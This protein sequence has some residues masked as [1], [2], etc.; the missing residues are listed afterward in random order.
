[1]CGICGEISVDGARVPERNVRSMLDGMRHRGPDSEGVFSAPGISAG[2][3]RLA[4]ID[5]DGGDQPIDDETRNV[6]VVFNGEIYNHQA[7]RAWLIEKGHRFRTRTDTEVLVHLWEERGPGLVHELE[8]MFAFCIH[9]RARSATFVARDRVGIKPLFLARAGQTIVFASELGVMLRHPRI[10]AR[11]DGDA[12]VD[13]FALQYVPGDRTIYRGI[14]RLMP[15]CALLVEGGDVREHRYWSIPPDRGS[16]R[17]RDEADPSELARLLGDAVENRLVADVPVGVFLSGG[18]DSA[19]VSTLAAERSEKRLQ[20]FSVGFET[21]ASGFDE[22]TFAR[23]VA[24]RLGLD[25][26]ELTVRADDAARLLP[27][28]I[29]GWRQPVTDPAVVPTYMLAGLARERVTVAL[30]GEGAD[31]LFGGYRRYVLD[32]RLRGLRHVPGLFAAGRMPGLSAL[33]PERAAQALAALAES[34]PAARHALW[35]SSASP[36]VIA[37][38]FGADGNRRFSERAAAAFRPGFEEAGSPL[39]GQLRA[40]QSQWL[41]HDLLEKV[42]HTTMARSLEARVPFLDHRIVEWAAGVPDEWKVSKGRTKR[43]LREAFRDR[44]P[45]TTLARPKRGFDLP[46]ADWLRGPLRADV[47]RRV[48][49]SGLSSWSEIDGA[50][51]E[52]LRDDHLN[53]RRNHGLPLFLLW[54][55]AI[56]LENLERG[57]TTSPAPLDRVRSLPG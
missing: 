46:L 50:A 9:D 44:L 34:D 38:L 45:E 3:T 20:S 16:S 32:L 39:A 2:M 41:P 55:V 57:G 42:D 1:M 25:H 48:T 5:L 37:A 29:E 14:R 51:A 4:V 52:K 8:G 13:L 22:R 47:E 17:G 23:E 53:G 31:E 12:L 28:L 35:A 10:D 36:D 30:S 6:S 7:L 49:K 33:L 27:L 15:G 54:S 26:H 24:D 40:D 56:F 18:I 21:R 43:I 11:L 19:I